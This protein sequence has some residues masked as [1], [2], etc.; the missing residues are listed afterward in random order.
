MGERFDI[1]KFGGKIMACKILCDHCERDLT[2]SGGII[3]HCLVLTDRNFGP[4]DGI[5]IDVY[6]YPLLDEPKYFC[7]FGC[8]NKWNEKNL[9]EK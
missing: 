7:G 8:L 5:V 3:D 9:E 4:N 2:H 1:E 6:I